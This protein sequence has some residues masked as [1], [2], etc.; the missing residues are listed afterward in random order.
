ME[1]EKPRTSRAAPTPSILRFGPYELDLR[2]TQLRKKDLK[3]CLQN[4][5]FQI[6]IALLERP[7]E[8]ILRE[9]IRRKLW[10]D[11]TVVEFDHGIN[12]AVKRLR[13]ALCESAEKPR[14][15][16]TLARRGY[17]FAG[18]VEREPGESVQSPAAF[19]V[20]DSDG[21]VVSGEPMLVEAPPASHAVAKNRA[22][23][24]ILAVAV[25]IV[26]LG[27]AV[28]TWLVRSS[29]TKDNAEIRVA[30]LTSSIGIEIQ[31][32]FSPDGTR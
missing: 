18:T 2:S 19:G 20:A 13:D 28:T 12:A 9:E 8:L 32:S 3:I 10:C 14:Y 24:P 23:L 25:L 21:Q 17:R 11:D 5:P 30:P 31:P 16:E 15:I 27:T 22:R 7:G 29:S 26:G 6:L 1:E 4:Q